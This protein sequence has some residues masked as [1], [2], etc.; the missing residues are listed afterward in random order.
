MCPIPSS[1][2]A[3]TLANRDLRRVTELASG[4]VNS[5][6]VVRAEDIDPQAGDERFPVRADEDRYVLRRTGSCVENA[7]RDVDS[8]RAD[9]DIVGY[10]VEKLPLGQRTVVADVVGLADRVVMVKGQQRSLYD[11]CHVDER[12]G[13]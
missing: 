11:V 6:P 4:L 2:Q 10:R 5:V 3:N 8:R 9:A 7:V 1:G 13:V 12:Q